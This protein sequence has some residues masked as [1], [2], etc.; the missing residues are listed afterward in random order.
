MWTRVHLGIIVLILNYCVFVLVISAQLFSQQAT[1]RRSSSKRFTFFRKAK[2]QQAEP[3][4]NSPTG[5][6]TSTNELDLPPNGNSAFQAALAVEMEQV[7]KLERLEA[8][9]KVLN[10]KVFS[11]VFDMPL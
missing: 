6:G 7:N 1:K 4:A 9:A 11:F 5:P 10:T 3:E 2:E 8:E